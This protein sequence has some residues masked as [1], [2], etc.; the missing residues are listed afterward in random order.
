LA[1]PTPEVLEDS[2]RYF[3]RGMRNVARRDAINRLTASPQ[4]SAIG[5]RNKEVFLW[6]LKLPRES[7]ALA[8]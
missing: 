2:S 8:P 6:L 7:S 5:L 1:T 4:H 3:P